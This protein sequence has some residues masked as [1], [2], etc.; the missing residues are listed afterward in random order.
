MRKVKRL[1]LQLPEHKFLLME[2]LFRV[3]QAYKFNRKT[4]LLAE[5]LIDKM[6]ET[7]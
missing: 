7:A 4:L 2:W 5:K 1:Q 6:L 3:K